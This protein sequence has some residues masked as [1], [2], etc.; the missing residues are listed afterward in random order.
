MEKEPT[1]QH[2]APAPIPEDQQA[3]G[4]HP[5]E[6]PAETLV[7]STYD[8]GFTN[9]VLWVE[10]TGFD[11]LVH[12]LEQQH[13]AKMERAILQE[14]IAECRKNLAE[15]QAA[16]RS[17][18]EKIAAETAQALQAEYQLKQ[19]ET[20]AAEEKAL[21]DSVEQSRWG[22]RRPYNWLVAL[23]LIVAGLV[24]I[25][26]D[27]SISMDILHNGL[28]MQPFEA[29]VLAAAL[30]S[31]AFVIKPAFDRVFEKP[32]LEGKYLQQN[33][34]LLIAIALTALCCLGVL[35]FVRSEVIADKAQIVIEAENKK[36]EKRAS[37]QDA[38][39]IASEQQNANSAEGQ[40]GEKTAE[41]IYL[42]TLRST[43]VISIFALSS[44]LFA[45]SGAV[46][47]GIGF[48][49]IDQL[50]RRRRLRKK[51]I[52]CRKNLADYQSGLA[53]IHQQLL[54][55]QASLE[56][57]ATL[58]EQLPPQEQLESQLTALKAREMDIIYR[59]HEERE[60][61]EMAWFR[62]GY[63]RGKRYELAGRLVYRPHQVVRVPSSASSPAEAR[64]P[65]PKPPSED[66]EGYLHQ[67]LRAMIDY[68]FNHKQTTNGNAS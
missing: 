39:Q 33:H 18:Q 26:A 36:N 47:F 65:S 48:P 16:R 66:L 22:I 60:R 28:D 5:A 49:A 56:L 23:S 10:D 30:A 61:T 68:N 58:L 19:L 40:K 38:A 43:G 21:L 15:N 53:A 51:M 34:A 20:R 55:K 62:E 2:P 35:G 64:R 54:E 4:R 46:C 57:A 7:I 9:G 14:E 31:L 50:R 41:G 6:K 8:H 27:F 59:M 44:I 1:P 11:E 37:G 45:L 63:K 12:G 67:R 25:G 24:F 13:L 3:E 32:Y 42:G 52:L 29:G 17:F